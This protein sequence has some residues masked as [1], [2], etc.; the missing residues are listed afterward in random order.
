MII[1]NENQNVE[2]KNFV[3]KKIKI[4]FKINNNKN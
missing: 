1:H 2:V 3:L 4:D